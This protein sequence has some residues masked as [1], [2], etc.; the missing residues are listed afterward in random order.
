MNQ[1]E[2]KND[3]SRVQEL[4]TSFCRPHRLAQE[5]ELGFTQ[6]GRGSVFLYIANGNSVCTYAPRDWIDENLDENDFR[7]RLLSAVDSYQPETQAI[8]LVTF[9]DI[10]LNKNLSY[11]WFGVD[12]V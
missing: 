3:W 6:N 11:Q 2:L 12:I 1:H 10:F 8:I 9:D 7:E 5:A 4:F